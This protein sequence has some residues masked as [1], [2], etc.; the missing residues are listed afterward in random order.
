MACERCSEGLL[1]SMS[2]GNSDQERFHSAGFVNRH[3]G[4]ALQPKNCDPDFGPDFTVLKTNAL[5]QLGQVDVLS[6]LSF[7]DARCALLVSKD[8]TIPLGIFPDW[9]AETNC[10]TSASVRISA[11][12]FLMKLV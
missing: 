6:C 8:F 7:R 9:M 12:C 3:F 5:A 1:S 2:A 4:K 11:V 10:V